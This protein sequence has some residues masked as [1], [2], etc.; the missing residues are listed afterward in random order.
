MKRKDKRTDETQ[1]NQKMLTFN[2]RDTD[3]FN[4]LQAFHQ[5]ELCD[6]LLLKQNDPLE[7]GV[8]YY[9][10]SKIAT[11]DW[12]VVMRVAESEILDPISTVILGVL[13][14]SILVIGLQIFLAIQLS[15]RMTKPIND[16]VKA[17]TDFAKGNFDVSLPRS[18]IME[19][20]T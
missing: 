16:F 18:Q 14:A 9:A 1:L 7:D 8:Y 10:G 3:Y 17:S 12:T 15:S 4:I 20:V 13:I 5:M 11:G 19:I 2:I 6:F